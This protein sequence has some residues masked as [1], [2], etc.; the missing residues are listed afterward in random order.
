M[1][2][3]SGISVI[4]G[5]WHGRET[6]FVVFLAANGLFGSGFGFWGESPIVLVLRMWYVLYDIHYINFPISTKYFLL[7]LCLL[8]NPTAITSAMAAVMNMLRCGGWLVGSLSFLS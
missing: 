7:L 3:G 5:R 1:E 4:G 6:V 8:L 2:K